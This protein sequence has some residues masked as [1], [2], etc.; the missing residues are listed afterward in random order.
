MPD[1]DAGS[2][3]DQIPEAIRGEAAF[4]DIKDVAALAT[5]YFNAQKYVGAPPSEIIRL[6]ALTD[7]AVLADVWTKLGRPEAPDKYELADPKP[8]EMPAGLVI[9]PEAKTAFAAK[10]HELG[11]ST[12]QA[13]ELYA[14][15]NTGRIAA[16]KNAGDTEAQALAAA[17]EALKTEYGQAF[18]RTIEDVNAAVDHFSQK[19]KLGDGLEKAI[20]G[21]PAA[22]R[23]ALTKLFAHL[24]APLRGDPTLVGGKTGAGGFGGGALSPAEAQQQINAM[25]SDPATAKALRDKRDPGHQAAVDRH[26]R[27]NGFIAAPQRAA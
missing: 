4:K 25:W 8:E 10:A 13:G 17:N 1:G 2:F 3:L 23:V 26:L 7:P 11:L 21:M 6:G 18:E 22:S 24:G 19:L 15:L 12:R 9:S 14:Y 27:L 20:E 5:S 16:F